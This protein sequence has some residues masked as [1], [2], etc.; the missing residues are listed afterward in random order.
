MVVTELMMAMVVVMRM[1]MVVVV[2]MEMA[3]LVNSVVMR[4][5]NVGVI[6]Q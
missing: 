1:V 3:E 6:S 5:L 2:V 4:I